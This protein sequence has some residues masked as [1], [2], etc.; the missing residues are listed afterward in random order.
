[1]LNNSWL[2]KCLEIIHLVQMQKCLKFWSPALPLLCKHT[3]LRTLV[4]YLY[5]LIVI[6][7]PLPKK[8][9]N[10]LMDLLLNLLLLFQYKSNVLT[11]YTLTS[12][13]IIDPLV[14]CAWKKQEFKR[15]REWEQVKVEKKQNKYYKRLN[16][17]HFFDFVSSTFKRFWRIALLSSFFSDKNLQIGI[18]WPVFPEIILF[19]NLVQKPYW[20]ANQ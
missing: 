5:I 4:L 13:S 3:H 7:I 2:S 17:L 12:T 19:R 8:W 10:L 15:S 18:L 16:T 1:M 9:S 11:L 20:K 6:N 14:Q